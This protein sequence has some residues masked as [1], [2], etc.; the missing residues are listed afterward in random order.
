MLGTNVDRGF[1]LGLNNGD[2]V[3]ET[4][5]GTFLAFGVVGLHDLD[6]DTQH[7]LT[8][9]HVPDCVVDK[10]SS[11]LTRVDHESLGELHRLGTSGPEFSR[12]DDLATARTGLH[13]ESKDTVARSPHGKTT[14]ELVSER[15][16]LGDR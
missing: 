4:S 10:V 14:E 7:T 16:G 5:S 2:V 11:G 1:G 9:E 15:F 13:D 3:W 8:E 6:F 12:D